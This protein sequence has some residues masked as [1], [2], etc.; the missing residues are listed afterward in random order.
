M[1]TV[2]TDLG[3]TRE[4]ARRERFEPS[5]SIS[6]TNT[7]E[8]VE[9]ASTD[10]AA[11]V[12]AVAGAEFIVA[13][14][15][16]DLTAERVA[17]DVSSAGG[18][19]WN[20][21]T[22]AQAKASL[23]ASA[24]DKMLYSTGADTWAELPT[25]SYGR[26]LLN[27]ANQA[28]LTAA[29]LPDA[30]YGDIS[31]SSGVWTIDNAAVSYAK[32]QN[33][34]ATDKVLGRATAGA[35]SV[36]E[37]PCT[38]AGRALLDDADAAA[39]LTTLFGSGIIS[40]SQITSDQDDYAPTGYA[41]AT[42][43]R[44]SSDAS[45]NITGFAAG[46]DGQI[47]LFHNVGAQDIV[48]NDESSSSTAA[49]R[50]ALTAD[51]TLSADAV[52]IL[53]YDGTSARW[54]AVSGGGGGGGSGAPSA[55]QGRLTLTSGVPITTSD[56]TGAATLYYTSAAGRHVPLWN[57]SSFT[58]TDFGGEL[59]N[60]T[61]ASSVG[62]AGPAAVAADKCYY[63]MV[64]E[65]GGTIRLTRSPAWA[66]DTDPGTGAGT[67]EIQ[68]VQGFYVNKYDITNGPAAGYGT[69]V[70]AVRSNG[71]S[72]LVDSVLFRWV[73]N[74]YNQ[75][76]RKVRVIETTDSWAAA[77]AAWRYANNS[78]ANRVDVLFALDGQAVNLQATVS[79]SATVANDFI[80]GGIGLD[81]TSG[82]PSD[83]LTLAPTLTATAAAYAAPTFYAG[84]P[85]RGRHYFA[86]LEYASATTVT[87][88]GDGGGTIIQNG[89]QGTVLN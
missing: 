57:G 66:S 39:Q 68:F 64:W 54:R 47:A 63:L 19:K 56:V 81:W 4:S 21:A 27:L 62:K 33:V 34:S 45:R 80:V 71:S 50:F 3:D 84:Y 70:G 85:G 60:D 79:A 10:A 22:A 9:E 73:S 15:S 59:S 52:A 61:T 35:G 51:L 11:A 26:G 28:A 69:V 83:N 67:A 41:T 42:V 8:A 49:N 23:Y 5:G 87:F 43:F 89:L 58:M 55:P 7:Q 25:T 6:S 72:Q 82:A 1:S 77:A 17:T 40:P 14:S 29:A 88:L 65:D 18:I 24:A 20:F 32:I 13:A 12:A 86:W 2:R 30:D 75:S 37:I 36:E 44:L 76:P 38:S 46:N 48:L 78:S 16:A 53:Q 31:I 74:I